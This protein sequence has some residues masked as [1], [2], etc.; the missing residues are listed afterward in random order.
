MRTSILSRSVIAVASLAIGSV[1][2]AA[3]PATAATPSGVT[4]DMVLTAANGVRTAEANGA[5]PSVAT[6]RALRAVVTRGCDFSAADGESL[7]GESDVDVTTAGDDADGLL[8]STYISSDFGSGRYC[9]IA[10]FAAADA[11]FQ[12]SG[13]ATLTGVE[14]TL[15][16]DNWTPSD[17][18]TLQTSALSGD[19]F[20]TAPLD[21][22]NVEVRS[23]SA[24]GNATKTTT[25]KTSRKVLDKK[26]RSEKKAAN[27]KY[28]Q[29]V[30]AAKK[31][32]A[33]ALDKAG[34]SKTKKAAAKKAYS[35]KKKSY[36]AK[37]KYA[38]AKYKIVKGTKKVTETRSFSITTATPDVPVEELLK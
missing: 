34:N 18:K 21:S 27:A 38:T 26:T 30:K 24:S 6:T 33:K 15:E 25:V 5:N 35:A 19:V 2:L 12:L 13:T 32:Y 17:V 1:A 11:S 4:R 36:K 16:N 31:S 28:D 23:A 7:D 14:Y 20:V 37:L 8:V 22:R 9:T 29:R 3:T 10:A